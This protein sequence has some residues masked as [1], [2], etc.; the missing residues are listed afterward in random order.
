MNLSL[1]EGNIFGTFI[2]RAF[3]FDEHVTSELTVRDIYS[4]SQM[5]AATHQEW[6]L[7]MLW[8]LYK[9]KPF[10]QNVT[11]DFYLLMWA[12]EWGYLKKGNKWILKI[13]HISG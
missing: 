11:K 4:V 10:L 7:E 1:V 6:P 8:S 2:N 13:K 5:L 3:D 12:W 9:H